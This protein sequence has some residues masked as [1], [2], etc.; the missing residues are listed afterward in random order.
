MNIQPYVD[1]LSANAPSLTQVV[2]AVPGVTEINVST[3]VELKAVLDLP[4]GDQ[5]YNLVLPQ[6]PGYP[7]LVFQLIGST[8]NV[9]DGYHVSQVDTYHLYMRDDD[10][11]NLIATVSEVRSAIETSS[12]SIELQDMMYDYDDKQDVY[13]AN[14]EITFTVLALSAQT[15]PAAIIYPIGARANASELVNLTRQH[16]EQEF[17]IM[18]MSNSMNL[19]PLRREVQSVLI[20][21]QVS[22]A[23]DPIEYS[24]GSALDGG[25]GLSL[26]QEVYH[27]ALY[28]GQSI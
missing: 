11:D 17:A 14:L 5:V 3:A 24:Q 8:P 25:G 28:V 19:E 4:M 22:S 16:E 10:I 26:W 9:V 6:K 15:L 1:L 23:Y 21:Q 20:G 12:W 27:D 7:N 18:L 2:S 13:R